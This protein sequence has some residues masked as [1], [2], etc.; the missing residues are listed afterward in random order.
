[1]RENA[2]LNASVSVIGIWHRGSFLLG[3]SRAGDLLRLITLTILSSI[4]PFLTIFR[5][6]RHPLW[7]VV[8]VCRLLIIISRVELDPGG[9]WISSRGRSPIHLAIVAIVGARVFLPCRSCRGGRWTYISQYT[10]LGLRKLVVG[11]I[12]VLWCSRKLRKLRYFLPLNG[13][14][15]L[16]ARYLLLIGVHPFSFDRHRLLVGVVKVSEYY[17]ILSLSVRRRVLA[18]QPPW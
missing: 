1:M 14:R 10:I 18:W 16:I 9:I 4:F 3:M 7:L 11:V 8:I 12:G 13:L 2:V 15:D 6:L 5:R 17:P